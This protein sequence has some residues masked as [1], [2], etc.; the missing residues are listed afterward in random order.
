MNIQKLIEKIGNDKI[1][2]AL[3]NALIV[4][5]LFIF[6]L[7]IGA[8]ASVSLLLAVVI[9]YSFIGLMKEAVWS[10]WFGIAWCPGNFAANV[11]GIL[12]GALTPILYIL[13][14]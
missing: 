4:S 2:Q 11:I 5:V 7:A 3:V 12:I 6:F 9:S 1:I 10:K 14:R 13:V 8:Q